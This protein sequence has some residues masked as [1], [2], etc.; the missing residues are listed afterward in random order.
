[1]A[2]IELILTVVAWLTP[3]IDIVDAV[4]FTIFVYRYRETIF[5]S[6]LSSRRE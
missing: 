6:R 4:V 1:M 5:Y 2:L 3:A